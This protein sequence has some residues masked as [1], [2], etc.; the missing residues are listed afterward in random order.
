MKKYP[1][2]EE[3]RAYVKTFIDNL[4]STVN[5]TET[6]SEFF[7]KNIMSIFVGRNDNIVGKNYIPLEEG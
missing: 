1:D 7:G 6:V 3:S 2:F 5:L 4:N